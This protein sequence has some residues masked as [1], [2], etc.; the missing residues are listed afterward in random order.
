MRG[1]IKWR[2]GIKFR[3]RMWCVSTLL[4]PL[5]PS[6]AQQFCLRALNGAALSGVVPISQAVLAEVVPSE[7]R[8]RAFGILGSLGTVAHVV[9]VYYVIYVDRHWAQCYY[10]VGLSALGLIWLVNRHLDADYGKRGASGT[11]PFPGNS[12]DS[13]QRS[14]LSPAD[15]KMEVVIGRPVTNPKDQQEQVVLGQQHRHSDSASVRSSSSDDYSS[16]LP[17]VSQLKNSKSTLAGGPASEDYGIS[18]P[19]Q[20]KDPDPEKTSKNPTIKQAAVPAITTWCRTLYRIMSIPTF[21]LLVLQGVPGAT[22][23]QALSFLTMYWLTLGYSPSA[24]ATIV[25]LTKLGSAFGAYLGGVFGDFCARKCS[26]GRVLV[27]QLSV[28]LGVPF[29]YMWLSR[30]FVDCVVAPPAAVDRR[31]PVSSPSSPD[32]AGGG[33][34]HS[35]PENLNSGAP[36]SAEECS[37]LP[38]IFFGFLFFLCASWCQ[39]GANRPICTELVRDPADR[40]QIVGLWLTVEG[41][42]SMM[43]GPPFVG[44]VSEAYGYNLAR[45]AP[46]NHKSSSTSPVG[47]LSNTRS[48]A[49]HLHAGAVFGGTEDDFTTSTRDV[50]NADALSAALRGLGLWCWGLCFFFWCF[51]Y[52]TYPGDKARAEEEERRAKAKGEVILAKRNDGSAERGR[53]NSVPPVE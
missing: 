19:R 27:A 23:W 5:C 7:D 28:V 24:A 18:P 9:I 13:I 4:T 45:N 48:S 30:D 25:A 44:F 14:Q 39:S 41:A 21:V 31:P 37:V 17:V 15:G 35:S 53:I 11:D 29:W 52:C 26:A 47:A 34:D 16:P 10:L 2:Q 12:V 22:P 49:G 50:Q 8:G 46:S 6:L 42:L 43:V 33:P 1:V 3:V 51:M 40:A 38:P 36:S 32:G 20:K